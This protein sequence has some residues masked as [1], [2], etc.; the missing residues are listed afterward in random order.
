MKVKELRNKL[1]S[2]LKVKRRVSHVR[3]EFKRD[4]NNTKDLKII[5]ITG[6]RGKSSTAYI[7]HEY[8]KQ[9]GYKSVLYSSVKVDSPASFTNPNEAVEVA[10][11]NECLY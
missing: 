11:L 1:E 2:K 6:S 8:L 9:L 5:G 7:V 3:K 4:E 10:I